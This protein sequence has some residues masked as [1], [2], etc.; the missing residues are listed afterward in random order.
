MHVTTA[1]IQQPVQRPRCVPVRD[2]VGDTTSQG[3]H[4]EEICPGLAQPLR[5]A[6]GPEP[7]QRP[8]PDEATETAA[9]GP[10]ETEST[11]AD[12]CSADGTAAAAATGPNE[13]ESTDADCCSAD[14]TAA[15]H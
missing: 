8:E 11:D 13:T 15:T 1:D 4:S 3:K 5:Q 9:T 14:G 12:C 6:S 2:T 7:D 10:N